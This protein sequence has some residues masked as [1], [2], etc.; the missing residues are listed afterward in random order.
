MTSH[1]ALL[2][3]HVN[4]ARGVQ[5]QLHDLHQVL[6]QVGVLLEDGEVERVWQGMSL[7]VFVS[8]GAS[9]ACPCSTGPK[10]D[11]VPPQINTLKQE[12]VIFIPT[13]R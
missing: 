4:S 8:M 2:A 9:S 1:L 12:N 6:Q 10:L 13:S 7:C 5:A 11:T 3:E